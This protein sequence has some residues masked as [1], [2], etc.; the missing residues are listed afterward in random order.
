MDHMKIT[1]LKRQIVLALLLV[2]MKMLMAIMG[3]DE[4]KKT[5]IWILILMHDEMRYQAR[6]FSHLNQID[7]TK[8]KGD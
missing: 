1:R 2:A 4:F 7:V 5:Q 3:V 6:Q 8:K